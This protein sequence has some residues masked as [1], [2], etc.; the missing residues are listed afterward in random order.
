MMDEMEIIWVW[1]PSQHKV[2]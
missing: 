1:I 2:P